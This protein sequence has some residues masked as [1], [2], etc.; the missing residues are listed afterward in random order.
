MLTGRATEAVPLL[1]R[2]AA[3]CHPLDAVGA[4]MGAGALLGRALEATDDKPGACRAYTTLLARWGKAK[5]SVT[6]DEA[7]ARSKKLACP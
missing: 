3:S 4:W 5:H 1:R 6:A 2:A 7:R